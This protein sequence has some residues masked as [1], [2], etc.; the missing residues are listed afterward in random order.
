MKKFL[1][2]MVALIGFGFYA[3]SATTAECKVKD[4][5][6]NATVVGSIVST[7]GNGKVSLTF[8]SDESTLYVNITFTVRYSNPNGP[9]GS[10]S[11]TVSVGPN[12]TTTASVNIT[13]GFEATS[14]SITG[15]RCQK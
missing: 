11:G 1:V 6:N 10:T 7:D 12:Q 13:K 4:S 3:S 14:L 9:D 15:A 5:T 2:T 8:S